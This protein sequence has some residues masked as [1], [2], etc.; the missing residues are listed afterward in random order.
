VEVRW[1]KRGGGNGRGEEGNVVECGGASLA[2]GVPLEWGFGSH[3]Y[4]RL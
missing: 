1:V 2:W 4:F 3:Q